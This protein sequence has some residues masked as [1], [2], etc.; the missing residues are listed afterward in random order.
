MQSPQPFVLKSR[1]LNGP[2]PSQPSHSNLS[3]TQ[4]ILI[5]TNYGVAV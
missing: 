5:R 3:R 4:T 2:G 1:R